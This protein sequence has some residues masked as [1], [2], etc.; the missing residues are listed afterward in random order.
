M[1]RASV[2]TRAIA[3]CTQGAASQP[4]MRGSLAASRAVIGAITGWLMPESRAKTN[5]KTIQTNQIG[6]RVSR[7]LMK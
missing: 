7:P 4:S 6:I 3:V 2:A 1:I 5:L